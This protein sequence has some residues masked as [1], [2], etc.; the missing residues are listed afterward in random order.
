MEYPLYIRK[1]VVRL[2]NLKFLERGGGGSFFQMDEVDH[3]S[4]LAVI[5]DLLMKGCEPM[6]EP[7]DPDLL[8]A[9][10][11]CAAS[12]TIKQ[13]YWA[14]E[15]LAGRS[16]QSASVQQVLKFIKENGVKKVTL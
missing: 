9:R 13:Q 16:D 14:K 10:E 1:E 3:S 11:L 5:A 12:D 2:S 15:C 7:V 6:K 4:T 8:L